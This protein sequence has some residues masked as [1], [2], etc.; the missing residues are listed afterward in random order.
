MKTKYTLLLFALVAIAQAFVPL[1]MIYDSEKIQHEGTVYKFRTQPIDPTD[2]FRGKYITLKFDAEELPTNDTTWVSREQVFVYIEN[3]SA[4][5][6]KVRQ[7]SREEIA[8]GGDYFMAEINYYY[9]YDKTVRINF[10][11]N[12]YYMEEGKAAEAESTY[13][14]HSR[15]GNTKTAYAIVAI[16]EGYTAITDVIV[17]GMPIREYVL[18]EREENKKAL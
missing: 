2:P 4:G 12:R 11:F 16:N 7:L 3:D 10:P 5:F 18:K 9:D 1:K 8:N 15:K 17:D 14:R 6:A 13:N